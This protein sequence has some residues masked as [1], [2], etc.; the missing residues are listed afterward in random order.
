MTDLRTQK[1]LNSIESTFIA[2]REKKKLENIKVSEP[3]LK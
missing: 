3:A 1:T 2:M